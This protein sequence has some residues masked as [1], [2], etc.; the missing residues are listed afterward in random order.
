MARS[1]QT[2]ADTEQTEVKRTKEEWI[3]SA[4]Y[5]RSE[6]FEI[7]GALFDFKT[8]DTIAESVVRQK[9]SKYKGGA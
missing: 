7:A 8:D 1:Q 2:S 6:R 5:L 9:M 3:V 4:A